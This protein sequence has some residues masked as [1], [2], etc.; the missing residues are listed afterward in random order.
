M[1]QFIIGCMKAAGSSENHASQLADLLV[2]ADLR[3]HYS[4]G[5][6]R[7][8]IYAEDVAT[9][10]TNR[11]GQPKI[12]KQRGATAWV[13]GDSSLGAIVGNYCTELTIKLAKEHGIGWVVAFNSNHYGICGHYTMKMAK[14]GLIGMSFTNTSPIVFPNR[15]AQLGLGTNPISVAAEGTGGD[16]FVLDMATTTV[17]LGK[18]EI[19]ERSGKQE[20]PLQ[21]GADSSGRPCTNPKEILGGGG[22][23]SLGGTESTG[24]YKGTGLGMMVELFCGILGGANY[25]KNIRNWRE[26]SKQANLGQCFVAIDPECFAPGFADR[27]QTYLSE[28]RSLKP[29]DVDK[30][31]L[32]A[33]DPENAHI[34]LCQMAGGL[35]YDVSIVRSLEKLAELYKVPMISYKFLQL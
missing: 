9:E 30:P 12:L 6:N 28:T 32:V 26:I 15:A 22:L 25:G 19:A 5:V 8:H 34:A 2:E 27:L 13:D 7:L 18:V 21:W 31:V 17:A 29:L 1:R 35:I 10:G 16:A 24:G 20:I 14:E 3:G 4:H 33:G 11:N 23:L